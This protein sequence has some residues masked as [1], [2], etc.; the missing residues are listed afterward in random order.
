MTPTV[1]EIA[2]WVEA[3]TPDGADL[4]AAI[5]RLAPLDDAGPGALVFLDNA[6]YADALTR[7]SATACLV[8]KRHADRVPEGTIALVCREPYRAYAVVA[9][10]MYPASSQ[11]GSQFRASGVSPGAFV[12]AE[13]RLEENVTVDPGAVVGPGA[14][15][16]SGTSIGPGAVVGPNVQIGRNCSIGAGVTLQAAFIGDRVIL[17]PGVRAGQDGFG[18]AMGPG[19]HLKV[20]Q[21]GRVII[22]NDV[23][24]GANCTIDRGANRDTVIGEGTKIDNLV[25]IAHNV[26]IGRHCIIVSQVGISGSTEIG[27]YVAIGGQAGFT[28]HLKIGMGAQIA[29]QAGV[30]N[31]IPAGGRWGGSPA[32]SLRDVWRAEVALAR[33]ASR[34]SKRPDQSGTKQTDETD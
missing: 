4:S 33:L 22:Q 12:H 34:D 29:A 2:A 9:A 7:S 31:D 19:G 25:Q 27:D 3:Q 28:G 21:L 6:K 14:A 17:H 16:G 13:A 15:I 26:T 5:T 10:R 23:E 11:P 18:F 30:M 32:R 8:G 1:A 20:P 24:I